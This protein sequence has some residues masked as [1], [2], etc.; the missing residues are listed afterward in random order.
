MKQFFSLF[1]LLVM[2]LVPHMVSAIP[3]ELETKVQI[4]ETAEKDVYFWEINYCE[5]REICVSK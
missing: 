1:I 2:A 4:Q 3:V 5:G